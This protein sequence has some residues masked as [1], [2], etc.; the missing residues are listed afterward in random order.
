MTLL[1]REGLE[2]RQTL[3]ERLLLDEIFDRLDIRVTCWVSKLTAKLVCNSVRF[4]QSVS[5]VG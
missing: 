2:P 5:L 3:G 1:V 4:V